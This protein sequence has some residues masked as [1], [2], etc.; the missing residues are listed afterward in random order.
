MQ[1]E[2]AKQKDDLE[3]LEMI[4]TG[5]DLNEFRLGAMPSGKSNIGL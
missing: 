1:S 5:A 4:R 3:S 2:L